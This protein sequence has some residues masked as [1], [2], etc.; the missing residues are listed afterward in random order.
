M[1]TSQPESLGHDVRRYQELRPD[2][3]TETVETSPIVFWALGLLEHHGWHLPVGLDGL[4]AERI[5]MRIAERA[6][7]V[8]L[9][10]MWW[11]AGGGHGDF[12]WT[13]YQSADAAE[14]ILV[15]TV[16]QLVT[17][18]FRVFVLLAGHYPWRQI[19]DRHLPA[20]QQE[21][22][23]V[24]FLWGTEMDIGGEVCL[25]G[26]H[27]AREETSYG[28]A[29]FPELV[30]LETLR[31][32]RGASTWPGG[33][34]PPVATRHPG[35]CFDPSEPLFA[36]MGQ[37]ARTATAERGEEAITRLVDH[38]TDKINEYLEACFR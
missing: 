13:H 15:R 14:S 29:L 3:L 27:A 10:T 21:H 6:G 20:F 34:G 37:D 5:C 9:P 2:Q 24:L 7:G 33:K 8:L 25:P 38:L 16:N 4:K 26:D 12:S 19:L 31:P 28:L 30:D 1:P 22:P 23:Q 18:G 36:Q 32:G 11:G 17:F 35:V